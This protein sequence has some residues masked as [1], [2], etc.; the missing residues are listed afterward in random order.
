MERLSLLQIPFELSVG[1]AFPEEVAS[2]TEGTW[3]KSKPGG[4]ADLMSILRIRPRMA[5]RSHY[6][7]TS[8]NT[9]DML[10]ADTGF[11]IVPFQYCLPGSAPDIPNIDF[12]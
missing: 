5:E 4:V 10:P 1:E 8:S 9:G 2:K 12:G 11:V 7:R 3:L 6:T